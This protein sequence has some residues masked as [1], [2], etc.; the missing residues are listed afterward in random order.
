MDTHDDILII[1]DNGKTLSEGDD[2]SE[3]YTFGCITPKNEDADVKVT[4][5]RC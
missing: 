5:T 2:D 1:N 3:R 4:F